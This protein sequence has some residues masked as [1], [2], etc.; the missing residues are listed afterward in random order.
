DFLAAVSSVSSN[1]VWAVG[2][3]TDSHGKFGTLTAHFDGRAW[4]IVP[5]PDPGSIGNQLY[6]VAARAANDVWA[7]GGRVD[8]RSPD[9]A[10]ILHWT[11]HTWS[12]VA[13]P[14]DGS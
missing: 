4:S 5:S 13:A 8:S 10:L 11:G 2:Y 3:Q 9:R 14:D 7:V 12:E 6:G 1:D